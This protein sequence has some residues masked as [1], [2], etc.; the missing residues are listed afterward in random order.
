MVVG[1]LSYMWAERARKMGTVV[2]GDGRG[3][4]GEDRRWDLE[5]VVER[6][7][8]KVAVCVADPGEEVFFWSTK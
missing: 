1:V 2:A 6:R 4:G 5:D 8:E 7:S 3:R